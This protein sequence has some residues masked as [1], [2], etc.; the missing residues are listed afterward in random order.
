MTLFGTAENTVGRSNNQYTNGLKKVKILWRE[1]GK[2]W[3]SPDT[4]IW[5]IIWDE[6]LGVWEGMKLNTKSKNNKLRDIGNPTQVRT[7]REQTMALSNIQSMLERHHNLWRLCHKLPCHWGHRNVTQ[8]L[9]SRRSPLGIVNQAETAL[10]GAA[11]LLAMLMFRPEFSSIQWEWT[12]VPSLLITSTQ[13]FW[14]KRKSQ[15]NIQNKNIY[16]YG[17]HWV[18]KPECCFFTLEASAD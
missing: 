15:A 3:R 12:L 17:H 5:Q 16:F 8:S 14:I 2:P 1:S 9:S 18:Y 4:H 10:R 6:I 11:Q 7:G 13:L